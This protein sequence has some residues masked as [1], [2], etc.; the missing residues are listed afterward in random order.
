MG[1]KSILESTNAKSKRGQVKRK[2][3]FNELTTKQESMVERAAENTS[4][5]VMDKIKRE[6]PIDEESSSKEEIN[7]SLSKKG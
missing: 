1:K 3:M 7:L 2:E 6:D 5:R 4:K